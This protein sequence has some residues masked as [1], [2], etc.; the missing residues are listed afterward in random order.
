ME[1]GISA[2]ARCSASHSANTLPENKSSVHQGRLWEFGAHP[3][4]SKPTGSRWHCWGSMGT[5]E[6]DT[7]DSASWMETCLS[8]SKSILLPNVKKGNTDL[9]N[10]L[11]LIQLDNNKYIIVTNYL[12]KMTRIPL[13]FLNV[14]ITKMWE[15]FMIIRPVSHRLQQQGSLLSSKKKGTALGYRDSRG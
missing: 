12:K 2:L 5:G 6:H 13:R 7:Y 10:D 1:R 4:G 15:L 14:S 11:F 3:E 8:F 9:N